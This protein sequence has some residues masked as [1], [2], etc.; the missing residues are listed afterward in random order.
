MGEERLNRERA[1]EE[2]A[3]GSQQNP[4]KWVEH[5]VNVAWAC[6]YIAGKCPHL[7]PEL[8]YCYGLLHDIGRLAGRSSEKH[9]LE[10]YRHCLKYGWEKA[11][12]ICMSHAYMLQDVGTAIGEFDVTEEEYQFMKAFIENAVYDDYDLLVQLCDSLA[13]PNGFCLLEKR[14]VD[15]ALRYGALPAMVPRWKQTFF[16]RKKFEDIIGCSV[17]DLLPG[18]VE[19]TF[20]DI[21][22]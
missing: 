2:L 13:L 21:V 11:A 20:S 9:L 19:A 22:C 8:A 18:V 1:M 5:S 6:E 16:I 10:G 3:K 4:G 12:Q 7:D 17:Y 15:V 14:F